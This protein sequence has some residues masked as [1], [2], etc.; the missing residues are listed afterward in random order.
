MNNEYDN[1]KSTLEGLYGRNVSDS[2]S[3]A[4]WNNLS[5]FIS[6][7]IEINNETKVVKNDPNDK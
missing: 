4:S 6:T 7:L 2:E 1:F 3:L 5:G